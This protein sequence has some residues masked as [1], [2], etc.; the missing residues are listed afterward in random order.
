[1]GLP[2]MKEL[3]VVVLMLFCIG[4]DRGEYV[5]VGPMLVGKEML[6]ESV[7]VK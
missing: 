2:D 6:P 5:A 1:M 4:C 3:I 7:E